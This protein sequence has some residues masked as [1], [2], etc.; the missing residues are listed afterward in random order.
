MLRP[1]SLPSLGYVTGHLL[2]I[3]R[4]VTTTEIEN[5]EGFL[6][7]FPVSVFHQGNYVCLKMGLIIKPGA[8]LS[9]ILGPNF[10]KLLA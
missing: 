3:R 2:I 4:M 9:A 1:V 5:T 7:S 8:K 10:T 6:E